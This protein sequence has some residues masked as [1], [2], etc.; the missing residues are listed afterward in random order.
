MQALME[1]QSA[2]ATLALTGKLVDRVIEQTPPQEWLHRPTPHS[3]H[4]LWIVG[5]LATTREVL[6]QTLTSAS[7]M[8]IDPLFAGGSPLHDD[9]SYP[10][11][12]EVAG[13]WR[14]A[15]VHID[16]VLEA[17]SVDDLQRPSPE[18]VPTFNGRIGGALAASV[19]HEAYHVGQLGYLMRCL[20]HPPLLGR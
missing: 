12:S 2:V 19:F 20:G 4:V 5:H 18:G 11:A 17:V 16:R 10:S 14:E 15:G 6:V 9:G 7:G 13:I 8:R 1:L 3:T